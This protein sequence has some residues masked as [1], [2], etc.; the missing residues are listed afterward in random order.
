MMM[1]DLRSK[2]F[3]LQHGVDN[4][5]WRIT[6]ADRLKFDKKK[7][8]QLQIVGLRVR[9]LKEQG[10]IDLDGQ[11][12]A[13]D[14]VSWIRTG[15]TFAIVLD[16]RFCANAIKAAQGAKLLVCESTY[17]QAQHHLAH[18]LFSYDSTAGSNGCTASAS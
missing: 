12:I 7:L 17:L 13:L 8:A 4:I 16:T 1:V 3:F 18:K 15:D 5:A 11:R 2:H 10:Y 14:D 6:E 9:Q